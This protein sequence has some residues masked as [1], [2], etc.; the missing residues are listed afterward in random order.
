M[1]V[2]KYFVF[3]GSVLAA[4]LV[5]VNWCYSAPPAI[6]ADRPQIVTTATIRIESERKRPEKIRAKVVVDADRTRSSKSSE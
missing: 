6:S 1:P 2:A 4:L 5:I 3:I